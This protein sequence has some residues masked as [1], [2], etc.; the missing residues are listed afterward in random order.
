[1]AIETLRDIQFY[2]RPINLTRFDRIYWMTSEEELWPIADHLVEI[3]HTPLLQNG[4][5]AT[6]RTG[7]DA[8]AC[9]R[10]VGISGS[11]Q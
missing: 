11:D 3:P 7:S 1:M 10:G 4:Y 5:S 9:L 6:R 8:R 2:S